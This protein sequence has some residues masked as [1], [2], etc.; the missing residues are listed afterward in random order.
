MKAKNEAVNACVK[1]LLSAGDSDQITQTLY[2]MLYHSKIRQY[3]ARVFGAAF[4]DE[5][6]V[7]R[8]LVRGMR[9]IADRVATTKN[10]GHMS[11]TCR[12]L[13]ST[14]LMCATGSKDGTVSRNVVGEQL[15]GA[16]TTGAR[17][18]MLKKAGIKQKR[19]DEEDLGQFSL[20]DKEEKRCKYTEEDIEGVRNYMVENTYTRQSPMTD[21]TV[22]KKDYNGERY[23]L[24]N[25]HCT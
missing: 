3:A 7:G 12:S 9:D 17:Y 16:Y 22:V 25:M 10:K 2:D 18:R 24:V 14:L 13:L 15:L 4:S 11:Q 20:V 21:D 1:A 5:A 19:F 8:V 6:K 23:F